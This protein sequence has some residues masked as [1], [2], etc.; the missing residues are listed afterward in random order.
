MRSLEWL[1][2]RPVREY[3]RSWI[4]EWDLTRLYPGYSAE[5]EI[6]ETIG[7]KSMRNNLTLA[8][9]FGAALEALGRRASE[10]DPSVGAGSTDMGDVSQAVPSIHP[11]LA[12]CDKGH[13]LCHQHAFAACA[14][15]ERGYATA[16][17]AGSSLSAM[18]RPTA[19]MSS[20][21]AV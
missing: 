12:I 11:Y 15:S 17:T 1:R 8:R 19:G 18:R 13:A 7:Y 14:R 16:L 5:V 3:V 4:T 9:R 6:E 10:A 2:S 21:T 20:P